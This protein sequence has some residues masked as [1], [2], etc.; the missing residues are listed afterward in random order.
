MLL[1]AEAEMADFASLADGKDGE[2]I[3]EFSGMMERLRRRDL[4]T[5]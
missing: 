1:A 2:E 5:T 3:D 4:E